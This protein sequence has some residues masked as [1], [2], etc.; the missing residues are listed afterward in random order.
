MSNSYA[1]ETPVDEEDIVAQQP[2]LNDE[3]IFRDA[4]LEFFGTFFFVYIGLS[5][6]NQSLIMNGGNLTVALCFA[7]GLTAGIII[8]GKSGGHLNPAVS[9]TVCLT[10]FD[11]SFKRFIAYMI[12]Q[13]AGGFFAGLLVYVMYCSYINSYK[14]KEVFAGTFGTMRSPNVS[15]FS[16]I[17]DQFVGSALLMLA[18]I[19]IPDSKFKP[20]AVGCSLGAL[21]IFHGVNGFALNLARDF[22]PRV[23]SAFTLGTTPFTAGDYWFWVPMVI[24]FLGMPFGYLVSRLLDLYSK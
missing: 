4:I 11:F 19:I 23:V 24:P 21:G 17:I 8:S 10:H 3:T 12:A 16:A 22:G 5:G 9:F 6:V 20:I 18:I 14:H 7:F 2:L 15:L 1:I 13:V